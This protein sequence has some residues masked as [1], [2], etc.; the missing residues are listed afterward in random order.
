MYK[1]S[2]LEVIS[3]SKASFLLELWLKGEPSTIRI[4]R[5]YLMRGKTSLLTSGESSYNNIK[6]V[7]HMLV[8]AAFDVIFQVPSRMRRSISFLRW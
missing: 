8:L 6:G 5:A 7:A 4:R 1:A 3:D 2:F